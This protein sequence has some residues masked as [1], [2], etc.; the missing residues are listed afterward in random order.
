MLL[1]HRSLD[2]YTCASRRVLDLLNP[3][4]LFHAQC[5]DTLID[6]DRRA[7]AAARSN[8]VPCRVG[9]QLDV[10]V[11]LHDVLLYVVVAAG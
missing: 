11:I 6:A 4:K 8:R 3:V 5:I 7:G 1:E 2:V 9:L 10:F